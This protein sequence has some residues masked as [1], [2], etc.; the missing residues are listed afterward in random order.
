MLGT[1]TTELFDIGEIA[2]DQDRNQL[3]TGE[4]PWWERLAVAHRQAPGETKS[5]DGKLRL[6]E[7]QQAGTEPPRS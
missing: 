6:L 3:E 1:K 4:G 2:P 5:L 7:H